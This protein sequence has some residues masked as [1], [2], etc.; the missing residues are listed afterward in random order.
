MKIVLENK[1]IKTETYYIP[2][3]TLYEGEIVVLF[4]YNGMHF[5]DTE[6][7]LKDIFC[8][9]IKHE[10]VTINRKMFFVDFFKGSKF[11]DIF[12]PS[13]VNR[14]LRKDADLTNPFLVKLFEDKYVTRKTKM[15]KLGGTQRKLLSLYK[16]FSKTKDIVFDVAGLDSSGALLTFKLVEETIKNGGSAILLDGFEEIKGHTSKFITLEWNDGR[17]PLQDKINLNF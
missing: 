6:M 2:P 13:K 12:F 16:T 3:F 9:V 17:L 14:Y 5:Y 11:R 4:L 7:Y 15:N 10:N 8:G 1:G